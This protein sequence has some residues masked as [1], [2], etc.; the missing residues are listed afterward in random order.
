MHIEIE[1]KG[2][3]LVCTIPEGFAV[4]DA[5]V[6]MTL[7]ID[8]C[9]QTGQRRVLIDFS[10]IKKPWPATSKLLG[11]FIADEHLTSFKQKH[12]KTIKIAILGN[13][14]FI[15]TYRPTRDYLQQAGQNAETFTAMDD[16][17]KWLIEMVS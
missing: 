16:A 14:P 13:P 7:I 10:V 1:D 17:E 3:H 5:E 6:M 12:G 2:T 15:S 4:S 9:V 11:A 8:A